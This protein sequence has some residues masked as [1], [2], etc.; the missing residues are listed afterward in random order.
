MKDT[1]QPIIVSG[2]TLPTVAAAA[3]RY[4]IVTGGTFAVAKGWVDADNIEGIGTLVV[5]VA[6]V[7]YGLWR[8]RETKSQ[9]I[10]TAEASPNY[11]AVV[12]K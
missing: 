6:T 1:D 12:N 9:L 5:T 3:L 2:M 10:T 11:V 7:L 8:T 4:L